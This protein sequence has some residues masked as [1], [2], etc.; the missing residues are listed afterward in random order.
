MAT[1]PSPTHGR[2]QAADVVNRIPLLPTVA[3]V[4]VVFGL[5][6]GAL[7]SCGGATSAFNSYSTT[8]SELCSA[9]RVAVNAFEDDS[10]YDVTDELDALISAAKDYDDS[11]VR[12][13]ADDLD[14]NTGY[15]VSESS[16]RSDTRN[17]AAEC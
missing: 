15:L 13:D 8:N 4:L 2:N 10:E 7:G 14:S 12:A 17:I 16:F 3:A 1:P 6:F 9:Y 11:G 5:L